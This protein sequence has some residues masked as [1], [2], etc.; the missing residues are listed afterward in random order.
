MGSNRLQLNADKTEVMWCTS[1]RKLSQH[2]NSPLSVAGAL[3]QPVE[4]L[5]FTSTATW[6]HPYTFAEQY[7]VASPRFASCDICVVSLMTIASARWLCSSCTRGSTMAIFVSRASG[8]SAKTSRV[9]SQRC[10][11]FGLSATSLRHNWFST[12]NVWILRWPSW[13]IA[14]CTVSLLHTWA[15]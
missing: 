11:P 2:P 6:V 3:V 14:C 12:L 13:R 10:C 5:E 1:T 8:I 9:C 4:T 7:P 15:S